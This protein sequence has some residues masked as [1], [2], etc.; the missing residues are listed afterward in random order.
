VGLYRP[1]LNRGP[2]GARYD[3]RFEMSEGVEPVSAIYPG[4]QAARAA[5]RRVRQAERVEIPCLLL[6]PDETGK[7]LRTLHRA[8][9][10]PVAMQRRALLM[11]VLLG[12]LTGALAGVVALILNTVG[13]FGDP[14]WMVLALIAAGVPI[15]A[16]AGLWWNRSVALPGSLEPIREALYHGHWSIVA[17][18]ADPEQSRRIA[19]ALAETPG[20]RGE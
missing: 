9:D 13:P 11:G 3:N 12:G 17:L 6:S 18:P 10:I 16:L 7:D 1:L 5:L 15:G 8:V 20:H 14:L 4:E 2:A 19:R